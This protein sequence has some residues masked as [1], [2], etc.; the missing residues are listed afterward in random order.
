MLNAH[1]S[2][3]FWARYWISD[4]LRPSSLISSESWYI[5]VDSEKGGLRWMCLCVVWA[6]K[7]MVNEWLVTVLFQ[8]FPHGR[9]V[10]VFQFLHQKKRCPRVP[11]CLNIL[12]IQPQCHIPLFR[13]ILESLQTSLLVAVFKY[14]FVGRWRMVAVRRR[15]RIGT[16]HHVGGARLWRV[17][18]VCHGNP[19]VASCQSI[20]PEALH[21][22]WLLGN[23][24]KR[25]KKCFSFKISSLKIGCYDS[26]WFILVFIC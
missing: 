7:E 26:I 2:F 4:L 23:C 6:R 8:S 21:A 9:R 14:L 15:W 19:W 11:V 13:F 12:M 22:P 3:F 1:G 17:R 25:E 5:H 24:R 20:H 16:H 10:C 18:R